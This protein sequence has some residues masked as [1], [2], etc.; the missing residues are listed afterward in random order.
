MKR[1]YIAHINEESGAVQ[2]IKE[3]SEGTAE[4]CEDFA[5][6]EMKATVSTAARLHDVGKY[7]ERFQH[8]IRG[9]SSIRVEHSGSGAKVGNIT[10]VESYF[11]YEKFLS[12]RQNKLCRHKKH[13][14]S[15]FHHRKIA[16]NRILRKRPAVNSIAES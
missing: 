16:C 9:D 4:L 15:M 13:A 3:H 11:S 12:I 6:K 8:R 2:T 14:I 1:I 7:G 5:V 10:D